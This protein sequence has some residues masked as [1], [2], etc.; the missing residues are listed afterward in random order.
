VRRL[1]ESCEAVFAIL[2]AEFED[3]ELVAAR[4]A[5]R[6]DNGDIVRTPA[7]S[8]D[9]P[10]YLFLS[11]KKAKTLFDLVGLFGSLMHEDPPCFHAGNDEITDEKLRQRHLPDALFLAFD[12][13][14]VA[15]L[16]RLRLPVTV[17]AGL[18]HLKKNQVFALGGGVDD[19]VYGDVEAI[20]AGVE[21][22]PISSYGGKLVLIGWSHKVK[23]V[24]RPLSTRLFG[25]CASPNSLISAA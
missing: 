20:P 4:I 16:R 17:A 12:M 25:T 11:H 22:A 7:M 8:V 2:R 24:S 14:D 15:I 19:E 18:S 9:D 13:Q 21:R 3:D 10:V 5:Q 6:I 1:Q 23:K